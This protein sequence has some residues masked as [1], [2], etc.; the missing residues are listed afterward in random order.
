M[1]LLKWENVRFA[2]SARN[3]NDFRAFYSIGWTT[4]I[5]INSLI[6]TIIVTQS[7]RAV[8]NCNWL[9]TKFS[10]YIILNPKNI[11]NLFPNVGFNY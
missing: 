11:R 6:S 4:H 10:A 3:D 5:M 2:K 1:R 8:I 9:K 7:L